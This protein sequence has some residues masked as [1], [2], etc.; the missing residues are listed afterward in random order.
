MSKNRY[1]WL[2]AA[3]I[4]AAATVA[5]HTFAGQAEPIMR[6]KLRHAQKVLEAVATA[7]YPTVE[8]HAS[9]LITLS[10]RAEWGVFKT[11]EYVIQSEDFRRNAGLLAKA[12][13][14]RNLDGMSL[15]YVQVTMN[16][17]NCHKHVR[18]ARMAMR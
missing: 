9:E 14:E 1:L 10:K 12:A 8:H 18:E 4:T 5:V 7:D 6:Q 11:P 3:G 17:F 16:C 13:K 2:T 15:A